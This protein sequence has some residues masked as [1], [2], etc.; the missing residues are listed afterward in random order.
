MLTITSAIVELWPGPIHTSRKRGCSNVARVNTTGRQSDT[1]RCARDVE[2]RWKTSL[3]PGNEAFSS[4]RVQEGEPTFYSTRLRR[5]RYGS[6]TRAPVRT[7][8]VH[9]RTRYVDFPGGRLSQRPAARVGAHIGCARSSRRGIRRVQVDDYPSSMRCTTVR[10]HRRIG[11][12]CGRTPLSDVVVSSRDDSTVGRV[13]PK[14]YVLGLP[15]YRASR[16]VSVPTLV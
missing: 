5:R 16:A 15:K 14:I 1:D 11:E 13:R 9:V 3:S 8:V 12:P 2:G 7:G 4:N 6:R 10:T